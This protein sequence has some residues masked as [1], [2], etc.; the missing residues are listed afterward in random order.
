MRLVRVDIEEFRSIEHQEVPLD[1]L[2]VLFGPNSAGKTTVLEAVGHLLARESSLRAD[3][4][5]DDPLVIGWVMFDLPAAGVPGSDD[6]LLYRTLLRGDYAGPGLLGT[7]E[8]PWGWIQ[9]GLTERIRGTDLD[10]VQALLV[11]SLARAGSEGS[12]EDREILAS[13]V[14]DPSSVYFWADSGNVSLNANLEPLSAAAVRAAERMASVSSDDPLCKLAA[15]LTAD[16]WAHLAW[17]GSVSGGDKLAASFPAVIVLDGDVESLSAELESAVVAVHDKMWH[18]EP[19][20]IERFPNGTVFTTGPIDFEIGGY[21][22]DDGRYVID[23]WLETQSEGRAVRAD[24]ADRYD[25]HDW[26]RVRHSLLAAAKVVEAEANRVAPGFVKGQGTIGVEVLPVAVWGPG[27]RRV[28]ATFTERDKGK[29]DLKVAGAGTSRWAAAAIRLA[30]RRL[31]QGR[32][33]V[34]DSAGKPTNDDGERRRI[35]IEAHAAPLTQTAVQLAPADSPAVYIADEPESHLHPAALQSVRG[36]LSQLAETAAAVLV[37]THSTAVLDSPPRRIHR[38]LVLPSAEGTVLR[39]MTGALDDE[40]A[41]ISDVLGL[42]KGELLLLARLALFVE[43]PHDQIILTEW[44]GDQLRAAGIHVFPVRGANNLPGLIT[45]GI[46]PALGIRLATMSD[47]TSIARAMAGTPQTKGEIAVA[48]LLSEAAQARVQVHAVGLGKPDILFYLDEETCRQAAPD[49]PG[50]EVAIANWQ[51]SG[52]HAP[53]KRWV[54]IAYALPLT[55]DGIRNLA[56][57]C[58][59]RQK[60]PAELS[61]SVAALIDYASGSDPNDHTS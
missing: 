2:V 33:V 14:F 41:R 22:S 25:Q 39:E 53:W 12:R 42:T 30:C 38:I 49:F 34:L 55:H 51:N 43:G 13:A 48:R 44:F 46:V 27:G 16:G 10:Q 36:W 7:E 20:T 18:F 61:E 59:N 50:W 26:Y 4:G 23:R 9:D 37:A 1:G 6:A 11:E 32:Q 47:G 58:K 24:I 15:K 29:R 3:P 28:R 19:E 8:D 5:D 35:V 45:A 56:R 17:L 52:S 40:L 31:M 21:A 60:I 54:K 57:E